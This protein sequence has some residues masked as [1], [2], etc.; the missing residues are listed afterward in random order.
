LILKDDAWQVLDQLRGEIDV[1][2][3]RVRALGEKPHC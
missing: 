2:R 3:G 1:L